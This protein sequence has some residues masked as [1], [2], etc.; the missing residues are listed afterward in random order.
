MKVQLSAITAKS[1]YNANL[2]HNLHIGNNVFIGPKVIFTNDISPRA[3]DAD[4]KVKGASDWHAGTTLVEDGAS[5]GAGAIIL[6]GLVIGKGAMVGAGS[7]VTKNVSQNCVVAG[8]P[9]RILKHV[10]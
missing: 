3:T 4:G 8:N 5:I 7:V 1:K 6:P 10:K 2:Y 9:A